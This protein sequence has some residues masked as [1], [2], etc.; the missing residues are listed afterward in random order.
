MCLR[1]LIW[2]VFFQQKTAY[3]MRSSDWSSDVCSAS[4][5]G[6]TRRDG[7]AGAFRG[8]ARCLTQDR[9]DRHLKMSCRD[10]LSERIE[11]WQDLPHRH[12]RESPLHAQIGR[13]EERRVGEEW[14][15]S[16]RSRWSPYH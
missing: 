8:E 4:R 6:L 2:L 12:D 15:S 11:Q 9:V 7:S 5:L 13:S 3:E 14:V 16:V 10:I 1:Q